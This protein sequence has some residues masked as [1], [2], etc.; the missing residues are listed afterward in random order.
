MEGDRR[1][2]ISV[3]AKDRP[4]I[5][6]EA[7]EGILALGGNLADLRESVLCSY[8]TMILVAL[9]PASVAPETVEAELAR[10]TGSKVSVVPHEGP[11]SDGERDG[12]MVYVLTAAGRDRAGLVAQVSRFCS[13]R[14]VN[15]LDLA[16]KVEGERYTMMLQVDLSGVPSLEAFREGLSR[17]GESSGLALAL[18]H[19][20]IFRA[21]NEVQP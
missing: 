5:V 9:F 17:L 8:F 2:V 20:D 21:T 12:G 11:L 10:A 14:G 7:T 16:S 4:G 13:E 18:Q 1:M 15:I 3:M 6:A 19:D